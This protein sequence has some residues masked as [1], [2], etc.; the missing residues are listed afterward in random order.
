[1]YCTFKLSDFARIFQYPCHFYILKRTAVDITVV[2][3]GCDNV[4]VIKIAITLSN[5]ELDILI[6]LNK[7]I[8]SHL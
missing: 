8:L 2:G 5:W 6:I 7:V 4:L 3:G 1:M